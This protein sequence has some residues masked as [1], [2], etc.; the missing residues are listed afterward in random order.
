MFIFVDSSP[1]DYDPTRV[2]M[3]EQA[4]FVVSPNDLHNATEV[5]SNIIVHKASLAISHGIEI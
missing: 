4:D 1:D 5:L 3:R 2:R